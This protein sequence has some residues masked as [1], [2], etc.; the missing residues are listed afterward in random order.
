[1]LK[2]ALKVKSVL[3]LLLTLI[4]A[5]PSL[6]QT[7]FPQRPDSAEVVH[8][9]MTQC[10]SGTMLFV[11]IYSNVDVAGTLRGEVYLQDETLLAVVK[12][13]GEKIT[14]VWVLLPDGT[15]EAHG[16]PTEKTLCNYADD[17]L[18]QRGTF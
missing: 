17:I 2:N 14:G 11:I 13:V 12:A 3:S 10:A 18:K 15:I 9:D 1:M 5:A 7:S 16:G 4:L 8:I 6:A